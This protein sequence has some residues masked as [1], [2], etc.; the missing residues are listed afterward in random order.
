MV[1]RIKKKI[2]GVYK[3]LSENYPAGKVVAN[4]YIRGECYTILQNLQQYS[5]RYHVKKEAIK[6]LQVVLQILEEYPKLSRYSVISIT[7]IRKRKKDVK[8]AIIE[9]YKHEDIDITE[10]ERR[11]R[12]GYSWRS[13]GTCYP[14]DTTLTPVAIEIFLEWKEFFYSNAASQFGSVQVEL[15]K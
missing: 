11:Y 4:N 10:R 13:D 2:P 6:K 7:A 1:K 8:Q 3:K 14:L 12:K 5:K 9:I 15:N